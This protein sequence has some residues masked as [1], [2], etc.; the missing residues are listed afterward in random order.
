GNT[1][2]GSSITGLSAAL[3]AAAPGDK[4][5]MVS[6]GSGAG[7]DAFVFQTTEAIEAAQHLAPTFKEM[8]TKKRIYLT[9]GE[10]VRYRGK[11]QLND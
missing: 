11:I 8:T 9:Y 6:F 7:S 10:Y 1:Y 4:I 2:S 5:L 3:D